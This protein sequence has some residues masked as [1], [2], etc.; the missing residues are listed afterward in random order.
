[1]GWFSNCLMWNLFGSY[2]VWELNWIEQT[3]K[4]PDEETKKEAKLYFEKK[5]LESDNSPMIQKMV[6][7]LVKA[8]EELKYKE[9]RDQGIISD[10]VLVM[11]P[12]HKGVIEQALYSAGIKKIPIIY[13][14]YVEIDKAYAI[15]D[16]ELVENI[17]KNLN[18]EEGD[19]K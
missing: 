17:K 1:M 6:E 14:D 7:S 8:E 5:S 16:K 3:G 4:E 13:V 12:E 15:T 11:S 10:V 18:W 2:E 9:L 19:E